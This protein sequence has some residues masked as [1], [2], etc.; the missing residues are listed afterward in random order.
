MTSPLRLFLAVR[1]ARTVL[2]VTV[3]LGALTAW[4]G[5]VQTTIPMAVQEGKPTIPLWRMIAMGAAVLPVLALTSPLADLE[6][7]T[8]QRLRSMQ[9]RYL[10]GLSVGCAAIYL[11]ICSIMLHPAVLTITARSWIAWF[12]LA[13][14]AGAILGWRLAWTLPSGTALVLWYWG[15][16]GNQHYQWWEF[17]ARP[18]DDLPSLVLSVALLAAGLAAYAATPWRRRRWSRRR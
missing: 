10:A 11:F 13:L 9:R 15:Y 5:L 7:V 14:I 3:L 8:T 1:P 2:A 17:S 16:S 6:Q 18:H 12:G 4:F